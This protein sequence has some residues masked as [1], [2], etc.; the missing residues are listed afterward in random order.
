MAHYEATFVARI[1]QQADS[2][3]FVE[4]GHLKHTGLTWVDDLAVGRLDVA[5][6]I[7]SL[8]DEIKARLLELDRTP[9]ELWLHRDGERVF[10]GPITSYQV[11]KQTVTMYAPGL[12]AYL[13]MMLWADA[14]TAT[15][16]DQAL[17]V[18]DLLDQYQ[19][20]DYGDFGLDTTGLTATGVTRDLN[21][22]A[23]EPR[24]L[25][26]IVREMGNRDNGF[27]LS[28]DYSSRKIMMHTP[29]RGTDLTDVRIVDRR[30]LTEAQLAISVAP[31]VFAPRVV[32]T[33]SSPTGGALAA[34]AVDA[35]A[36]ARF[37]RV[38]LAASFS[39]IERQ[40]TLDDHA[41]KLV[42]T[43][44]SPAFVV[45]P[46]IVPIPDLEV[47]DVGPGDTI[48]YDYDIGFGAQ[49]FERRIKSVSVTVKKAK[50]R[51][52]VTFL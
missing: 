23:T 26:S 10:A 37:G 49:T 22:L 42:A 46:T 27:D 28:V 18:R 4:L 20:F 29:Q 38:M 13:Q 8:P 44:G 51:M 33:S 1:P 14:Y 43:M 9:N 6:K 5:C 50:E 11:Q 15:D 17:I 31:G 41:T 36:E 12:L 35:A 30:N 40:A 21:L 16:G 19:A 34:T 2:P 39:N 32:A 45:T 3:Q 25:D 48:T 24:T 52:G 47:G 7:P